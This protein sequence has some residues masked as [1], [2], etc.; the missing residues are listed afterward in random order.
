MREF[1]RKIKKIPLNI[2]L[3][4]IVAVILIV[5]IIL[6]RD[7]IHSEASKAFNLFSKEKTDSIQKIEE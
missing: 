7:Y 5:G 2:K 3:F 6:R 4:I 1:L